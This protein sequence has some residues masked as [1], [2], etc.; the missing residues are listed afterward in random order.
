MVQV[1]FSEKPVPKLRVLNAAEVKAAIMEWPG[2]YETDT[3]LKFLGSPVSEVPSHL[4]TYGRWR[5]VSHLRRSDF[6][7]MGLQVVYARYVGGARPKKFCWV[8]VAG[9]HP[10]PG[11]RFSK[12]P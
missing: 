1:V 9:E 10:T 2:L 7:E 8:V 5:N 4:I 6:E 12:E 11:A 3:G